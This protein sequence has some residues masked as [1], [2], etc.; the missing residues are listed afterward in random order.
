MM[1]HSSRG[2]KPSAKKRERA[3]RSQDAGITYVLR[4]FIT[5]STPRAK[6][7]VMRVKSFC[8][9]HL[10]NHYQLDVIDIYQQPSFA[11]EEQ[12]IAAPTLIK[13]RPHPSKRLV[14]DFSKTDRVKSA[15]G[16]DPQPG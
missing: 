8:E 1:K 13:K 10:K 2:P 14:G 3:A 6:A 15:L 7:A 9:E 16:L 11:R 4:L 5:G 12:V